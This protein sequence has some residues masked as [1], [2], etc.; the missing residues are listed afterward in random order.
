MILL[1]VCG[2]LRAQSPLRPFAAGDRIAFVGNSITEAGYYESYVWLY[3]MLHFPERRI[4][5]YNLGIGGDRAKNILDRLDDDVFHREPTVIALT[6]GMN[7]SGYFEFL[8]SD[9]DST[10]KARLADCYQQFLGIEQK[11]KAYTG[12]RKILFSTSPYDE[13]MSNKNNLF[14]GK[15]ALMEKIVAFQE[16]A[17]RE[18]R[19]GW[20]DLFHPMTEIEQRE[21]KKD[22]AFTLTGPDRIHPGNMGHFVMATLFL[23]AQGLAGGAV[24]GMEIDAAAHT[25]T[26]ADNCTI[27]GL[28]ADGHSLQF[29]YLAHS[30]PFPADSLSRSPGNPQRQA[31]ALKVI[32][33]ETAFNQERLAV[34][35]L[36]AGSYKLTIDGHVIGEYTHE[37]LEKGINLAVLPHTP[38]YQQAMGVLL[39]NE[40]RMAVEAKLRAYYWLQFDFFRGRGM[41]YADDQAAMDSVNSAA[42]K[43]WAVAS[44]RDNYKTA[45]Y[46]AVRAGWQKQMEAIINE[47]YVAN[48]P[49]KRK[50]KLEW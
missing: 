11:L 44:K 5:V 24:A 18:N 37:A 30:L 34:K 10:A 49:L 27:T 15:S 22:S 42:G 26:R 40:E 25:V 16:K 50:V 47:I 32:P 7:D 43:D 35:G 39:L 36:K 1:F 20:V 48:K 23:K 2:L 13:T 45:R 38:E 31:D 21:Q 14:P 8:R 17:A 28:S 6:F 3:Y 41:M 29:D 4:T 33:F 9:A 46:A 12:A 19:W